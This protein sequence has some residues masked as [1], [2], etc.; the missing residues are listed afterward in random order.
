MEGFVIEDGAEMVFMTAAS[1][2]FSVHVGQNVSIAQNSHLDF[3]RI[4]EVTIT[5]TYR[6]SLIALGQ[7]TFG[8]I[9]SFDFGNVQIKNKIHA[10]KIAEDEAETTSYL[11]FK[12]MD[13]IHLHSNASLTAN[14]IQIHS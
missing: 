4:S 7:V 10:K 9:L 14:Y 13:A 6:H 2:K 3:S 1:T 11:W 5:A 12:H 8:R